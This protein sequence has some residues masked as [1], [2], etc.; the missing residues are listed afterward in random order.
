M[1]VRP[2]PTKLIPYIQSPYHRLIVSLKQNGEKIYTAWLKEYR[3]Q[4]ALLHNE[5]N[6]L[7]KTKADYSLMS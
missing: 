6:W 5:V 2:Q 1:K 4:P 3:L 7:D